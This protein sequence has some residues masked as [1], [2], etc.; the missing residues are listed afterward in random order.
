M[1]TTRAYTRITLALDIVRKLSDGPLAGY[2]ELG[3]V[4]HQ[5]DLFDTISVVEADSTS[6][7]CD[8]PLVPRDKTNICWRAV[9]LVKQK[10]GVVRNVAIAI[11]KNIPVMGGLAGGS[12]RLCGVMLQDALESLIGRLRQA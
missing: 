8:H 5:I 2:H 9:D 3:I 10:R 11:Q 4:K 6:L 1:L 12:A 7:S